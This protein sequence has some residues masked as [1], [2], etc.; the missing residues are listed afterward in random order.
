TT[1][2]FEDHFY[3]KPAFRTVV[4]CVMRRIELNTNIH[5]SI[6]VCFNLSRSAELHMI[7]TRHTNETVVKGRSNGLFEKND[8]VTWR[9]KH[10]GIYQQLEMEISEMDFPF[11]FEDRMVK[12]IFKSIT[13]QHIFSEKDGITTMKDIF[14]YETPFGI[15]G[16]VFDCLVLRG[17]M[18]ALLIRRNDCIRKYAESGEW[19]ALLPGG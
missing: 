7:S 18:K 15:A 17:Y 10:F 11:S 1:S 12:G 13:H 6:Q 14:V 9:A 16:K 3:I 5:A 8:I 19:R 4:N 2:A